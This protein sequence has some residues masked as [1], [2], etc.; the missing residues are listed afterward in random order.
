VLI[1]FDASVVTIGKF[2]AIH[3]GHQALLRKVASHAK[4]AGIPSIVIKFEPHP[5]R[6][7]CDPNYKPIFT[8]AER[9]ELIRAFDI[10]YIIT[11]DFD[12]EF[13]AMSAENFCREIFEG[14]LPR[15]IIVGENYRFGKNRTG[16]IE[17]LR[18]AAK[19]HGTVLNVIKTVSNIQ[20]EGANAISTSRIREFLDAGEF[21]EAENLL[22]FPFFV[23]GEVAHGRKL[24]RTLGFPTLNLYPA[25]EKFLPT[26]GVYETRTH[27]Q[28]QLLP[29]LTNI[30]VRPTV[31]AEAQI[32][33]ETH[34][35]A[36]ISTPD[37]MYGKHIKVEFV[38]FIRPERKFSNTQELQEQIAKD[39]GALPQS[40]ENSKGE[41]NENSHRC[42]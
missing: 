27:I 30:G 22:G 17:T 5:L 28:G 4:A 18:T 8:D 15:E 34:I 37:E 36:L 19:A 13:A 38:R 20:S 23:S 21:A 39:L 7:L 32:S 24:G 42:F 3:L 6:F 9:H 2:E 35:P 33:A 16:T 26:N 12:A 29:S 25:A 1:P 10:D 41:K 31:S 11:Y 14:C 40:P